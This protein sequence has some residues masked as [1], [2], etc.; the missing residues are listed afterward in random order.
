VNSR[1]S[2]AALSLCATRASPTNTSA[3]FLDGFTGGLSTRIAGS[4]LGFDADCAGYGGIA[5]YAGVVASFADGEGELNLDIRATEETR[6]RS[7]G[8]CGWGSAKSQRVISVPR[9]KGDEVL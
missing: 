3:S 6:C 9:S 1:A 4:L 5:R 2:F 8:S 7:T